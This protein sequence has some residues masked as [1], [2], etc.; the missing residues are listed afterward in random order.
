MA[1][2]RIKKLEIIGLQKDQDKILEFLQ[3]TGIVE[4]TNV[5]AQP[6]SEPPK[7]TETKASLDEVEQAIHFLA[8]FQ[9]KGG[10]LEGIVN[11]KPLV[12]KNQLDEVVAKFDYQKLLERLSGLQNDLRSIARH[13]ERLVEEGQL[14][15]GWRGLNIPLDELHSTDR[16]GIFLGVLN[17]RDYVKLLSDCQ[18]DCKHSL[19]E[20]IHEDKANIYLA[21]FYM[22]DEF[23]RIEEVLKNH[24]FN[25]VTLSRHKGT[26]KDRLR[27]INK[28]VAALDARAKEINSAIAQLSR[29]QFKL[30][31]VYDYL[32]NAERIKDADGNLLKQQFTFSLS[33]WIRSRDVKVLEKEMG[34]K[35]K[36][37]ALFMSEP[38][39][40]EDI[41]IALENK[42]ILQPFEAVTNL[43]G[44]PLY[45]GTDPTGYLAPFFALSFGFC[46]LDAGYGLIL[47]AIMIFFMSRKQVSPSS[48]NF[49]RLFFFM[50][51]SV[52]FAG[53]ITG[54]FF[55]DL[56][57]RL[58]PQFAV[59]QNIQ[60]K[61]ILFNPV[62]DSLL[63]L[64]LALA[65]GFIQVWIGVFIRFARNFRMDKFTALMLDLPTLLV[66]TS[67]LMLVLIFAGVLPA[68]MMRYALG[69]FILA[70]A[71]VIFYQWKSNKEISLKIFWSFFGIYSVVTG[72]F[73]ADTLSFSRIFALGLTGGLLAIAINTILF[74]QGPIKGGFALLG[75]AFAII[76]MIAA[77]ILNFA[78]C[79]LGAYVHTS[80]LQYLEF[81]TKFF[82]SGGRP[83][84]PL[85]LESKY[86]FLTEK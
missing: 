29:E 54:G 63:F 32:L 76:V 47:L 21:V 66:Q 5:T 46:M 82:E 86:I 49:M 4:L 3:K 1:I 84:R 20:V 17:S 22:L 48:R 75:F 14:L 53:V 73:L 65:M 69:L 52:I 26:V 18:E 25:F 51:I 72:N 74:P 11:L 16:C 83:F 13:K 58:P 79:M 30:M 40:G 28:E 55:G 80:R 6:H 50:S 70:A 36:E 56:I 10:M 39:P 9:Q 42:N 23:E 67:L 27:D 19:L 8:P 61:L 59:I 33:G 7:S 2:S 85:K 44:Q 60:K 35:F 38:K 24:R 41:P 37:V 68:F 64:G 71:S 62:K 34:S 31:V 77:H 15:H 81:F 45:N 78:I 12:Y 57:S 43:Y